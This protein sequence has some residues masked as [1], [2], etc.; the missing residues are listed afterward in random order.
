MEV[1]LVKN[2]AYI[3]IGFVLMVKI[4]VSLKKTKV[5]IQTLC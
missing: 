3:N 5:K 4:F 1:I 2:K